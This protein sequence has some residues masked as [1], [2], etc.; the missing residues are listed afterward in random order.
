VNEQQPYQLLSPRD[1]LLEAARL[2]YK[3][4][5]DFE[6]ARRDTALVAATIA[7]SLA[8]YALASY[9]RAS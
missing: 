1:A 3:A 2:N 7:Q 4:M 6:D 5:A 8:T 9:W